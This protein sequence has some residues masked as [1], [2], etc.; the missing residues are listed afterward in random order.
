MPVPLRYSCALA[1]TLRGSREYGAPVSG[2][3]TEKVRFSVLC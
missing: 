2:S 1:A 3:Y